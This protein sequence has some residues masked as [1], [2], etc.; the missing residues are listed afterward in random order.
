MRQYDTLEGQRGFKWSQNG[1]LLIY[2]KRE[3]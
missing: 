2:L 3:R 1:S